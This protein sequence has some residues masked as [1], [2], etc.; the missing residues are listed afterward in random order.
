ISKTVTHINELISRLTILRHELVVRPVECDLNQLVIEAL[1]AQDQT[2]DIEFVKELR[3]LPKLALDP[4]QIEKVVTNLLLNAREAALGK[5]S[6][7]RLETSQRNGCVV[8]A[9]TDNGCGMAPE[10]VRNSLFRPFQTTK[11]KGIGIG[12]FHC[13]MIV[14]A[15]RGKIEVESEP[16]KGTTFRVLLPL[17]SA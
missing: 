10:F 8:L 4:T 12:M 13:K 14:E 2:P 7:I 5:P 16:G 3:P 15:H 17:G 9:V 11:Q 1:K 6:Q